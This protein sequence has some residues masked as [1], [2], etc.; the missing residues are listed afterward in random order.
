[1]CRLPAQVKPCSGQL[2]SDVLRK[3]KATAA[4]GWLLAGPANHRLATIVKERHLLC[5]AA[6]MAERTSREKVAL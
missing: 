5:Q 2:N 4:A 1:M 6:Q 3:F